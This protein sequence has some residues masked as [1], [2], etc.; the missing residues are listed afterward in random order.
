MNDLSARTENDALIE[1]LVDSQ[2]CEQLQPGGFYAFKHA[3]D[4]TTVD[5]L[6]RNLERPRRKTGVVR[7]EDT[8]SF[9]QYFKKHSDA[10]SEVFVDIRAGVLTAVL[11]AHEATHTEGYAGS[12]DTARWGEHRLV[13]RLAET[14]AWKRW[15]GQ[16]RQLLKQQVFADFIDDNR[17]DIRKPS[18]ADMLELVQQFQAKTKVTFQSANILA[19]GDRRLTFEE[20][21]SAGGGAKGSI[22]VPS[23][24]ELGIAPFE[25][26]EPYVVTARFR[27]RIQGGGLFMGYLL[28]NADDVKR[29][30]VK[31]VVTKVSEELGIQ[32]M[33]GQPS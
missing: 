6:D 9:V 5:L 21:T 7:V 1:A 10:A 15:T 22:E 28:D 4:V 20:E 18:A 12:G 25:D 29:D 27:Y 23:V 17:A 14:D 13:L 33:R 11:D 32:I 3:D 2:L 19:N 8:A 30:A 24:L 26:S 16:D 31:T